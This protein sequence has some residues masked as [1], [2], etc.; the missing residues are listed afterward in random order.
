MPSEIRVERKEY[1]AILESTQKGET[2]I[3]GWLTWLLNCLRGAIEKAD[4][5]TKAVL[6]NDTFWWRLRRSYV[7][8]K[9][10]LPPVP[11]DAYQVRRKQPRALHAHCAWAER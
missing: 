6:E 5:L 4:E 7:H 2:D 11:P 3:T 8:G 1:Y 9:L 10:V